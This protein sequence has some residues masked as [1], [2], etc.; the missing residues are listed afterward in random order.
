MNT[1]FERFVAFEG[2]DGTGKSCWAEWLRKEME[3]VGES[4]T[5]T[6]EPGA[7]PTGL[8]LRRLL[9]EEL[10]KAPSPDAP[11]PW[12]EA[13]LFAADQAENVSKVIRPALDRGEFVVADRFYGSSLAYQGELMG[14]DRNA[15]LRLTDLSLQGVWPGLVIVLDAD[16]RIVHP[17]GSDRYEAASMA[18]MDVVRSGYLRN[19]ERRHDWVMVPVD[20][21]GR[22]RPFVSIEGSLRTVLRERLGWPIPMNEIPVGAE[23]RI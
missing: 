9:L 21:R 19:V 13:M 7:T 14:C 15:L 10:P 8:R 12:T 4:A 16:P 6:R 11:D 2:V 20:W 23:L 1:S 17:G 5:V 18:D 3:A 22:R